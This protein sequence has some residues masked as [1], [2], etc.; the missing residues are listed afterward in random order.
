MVIIDIV[1]DNVPLSL[2]LVA[3][4]VMNKLIDIGLR[5]LPTRDF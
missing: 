1:E 5:I 3:Q 4:P 2:L